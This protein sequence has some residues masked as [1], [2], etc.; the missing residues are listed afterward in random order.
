M[1]TKLYN[2][3]DGVARGA[4]LNPRKTTTDRPIQD[5]YPMELSTE[6]RKKAEQVLNPEAR[7]FRPRRA[8]AELPKEKVKIWTEEEDT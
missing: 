6:Q 1:I 4:Q 2:G 3:R 5:L 7:V 8:A